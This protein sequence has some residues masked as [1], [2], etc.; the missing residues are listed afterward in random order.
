MLKVMILTAGEGARLR[1]LTLTV[2]KPMVPIAHVPLLERTVTLLRAQGVT[3]IVVNLHHLG[4]Q[5]RE[6]FAQSLTYSEESTLLGTAGGVKNQAP[7]FETTFLVLYGDNL[8]DFELAPLVAFHRKNSA[9]ATIATFTTPNPTACGLVLTDT[10]GRVTR[11]EEKP[12]PEAVF[13]HQANAGVYVLEPEVLNGIPE[14]TPADFGRDLFPQLLAQAPGRVFAMPL[15]GYLQDTGTPEGY[16]K[17]SWDRLD[18]GDLGVHPSVRQGE[19]VTLTGKNIIGRGCVLGDNVTLHNS[20]LWE[21]CRIGQGARLSECIL[22]RN[23]RIAAG[24]V[25]P[26]GTIR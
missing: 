4:E 19:N 15:G 6:H 16:R 18:R 25:L 17:A 5:I 26:E 12:S 24:A 23:T 22:G 20:I 2:P 11:F 13:T 1:P 14:K 9:L 7:L 3:E 8:Y 10:Q 21:G